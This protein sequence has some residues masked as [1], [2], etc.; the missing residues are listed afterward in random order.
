MS[1]LPQDLLSFSTLSADI[2]VQSV[3]DDGLNSLAN[4][5]A[6][7]CNEAEGATHTVALGADLQVCLRTAKHA[8]IQ[9]YPAD[10]NRRSLKSIRACDR[11]RVDDRGLVF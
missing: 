3:V 2:R 8:H 11:N 1:K 4:K 10:Q 5:F 9:P 7:S 6:S